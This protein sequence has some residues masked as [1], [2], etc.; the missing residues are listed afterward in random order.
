MNEIYNLGMLEFVLINIIKM[1]KIHSEGEMAFIPDSQTKKIGYD[2]HQS[3]PDFSV[4]R[5]HAQAARVCRPAS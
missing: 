5:S 1:N 2:P 4:A 3:P